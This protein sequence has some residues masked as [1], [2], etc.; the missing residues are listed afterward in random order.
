VTYTTEEKEYPK[1]LSVAEEIINSL[2]ITQKN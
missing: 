2:E 1:Y